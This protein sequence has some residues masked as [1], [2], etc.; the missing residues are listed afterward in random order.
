MTP[1]A[2]FD[3]SGRTVVVTGG[4]RGIGLMIA[5]GF[6]EAGATVVI[7]SRKAEACQQAA[8][9]LSASGTCVAHPAD[10]STQDGIASLTERVRELSSR[11]DVLVNNAGATWGAP[12]DEFPD[13]GFDKVF[14]VNVKAIFALTQ[15]L[16]PQLRAASSAEDPARVINIGSVDG[17]AVS[18]SDNFSYGASKAA[19][20]MLTRKLASVTATD[21]ITVNAIAPGPFPSKMMAHALDDPEHRSEIVD[22][23][24]LGRPG[25]PEDIAGTAVFLASRAGAYLTGTVIPVDGGLTGAR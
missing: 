7:S 10:L 19:V 15:Q 1:D 20:H 5:R 3:V 16:L 14:D 9:E 18:A 4:S 2:L 6:V 23:I 17:I 8:D 11:V 22:R 12:I 24:P 21:G 25:A 13:S